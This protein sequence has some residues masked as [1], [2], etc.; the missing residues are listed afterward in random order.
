MRRATSTRRSALRWVRV[1]DGPTRAARAAGLASLTKSES[2]FLSDQ[3]SEIAVDGSSAADTATPL[4]RRRSRRMA[5][6]GVAA[7]RVQVTSVLQ[8]AL[9]PLHT[10]FSSRAHDLRERSDD[11]EEQTRGL[12]T[13]ISTGLAPKREL[14]VVNAD[15]G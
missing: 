11:V 1:P 12:D 6:T 5:G 8:S 13:F 10:S 4:G 9:F 3:A 2:P 14:R 15:D 7:G